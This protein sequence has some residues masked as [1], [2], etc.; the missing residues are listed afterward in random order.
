MKVRSAIRTFCKH[1]YV[2]RRGKTRYVYCK[3]NPKH[4]QRQGFHTCSHSGSCENT[5]LNMMSS[6]FATA[7]L[8]PGEGAVAVNTYSAREA[9]EAFAVRGFASMNYNVGTFL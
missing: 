7:G 5:Q 2:V 3:K 8:V 1:C 4:K 9:L 6:A